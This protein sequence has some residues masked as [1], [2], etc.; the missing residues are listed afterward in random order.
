MWQYYIENHFLFYIIQS[1]KT[2]CVVKC[3]LRMFIFP[4]FRLTY[5]KSHYK[6]LKLTQIKPKQ[7]Q[8]TFILNTDGSLKHLPQFFGE[9]ETIRRELMERFNRWT[10]V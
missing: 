4:T 8:H 6:S 5:L 7:T 1:C 10:E 2:Y 9:M 3:L